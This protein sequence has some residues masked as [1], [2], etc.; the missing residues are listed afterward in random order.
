MLRLPKHL[1]CAARVTN[2]MARQRC[3]GKRSM[4]FFFAFWRAKF[5]ESLLG[6]ATTT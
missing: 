1:Y 6:L 4:T 3:F 2:P 5:V